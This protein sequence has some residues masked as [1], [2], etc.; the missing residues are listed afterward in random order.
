MNLNCVQYIYVF[1]Y[2]YV[3]IYSACLSSA[4]D[5]ELIRAGNFELCLQ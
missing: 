3:Y 4:L 5:E 1:M 2:I